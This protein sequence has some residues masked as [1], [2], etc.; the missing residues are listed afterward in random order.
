MPQGETIMVYQTKR[1]VVITGL[2]A[3]AANGIG[4][5]A[6]WDATSK[7]QSGIKPFRRYPSDS[8]PLQVAGEISDFIANDYM[9]RKLVNRTDRMTHFVLASIQEAMQDAGLTLADEDPRR[10]GA[11]IANTFGGLEY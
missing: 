10:V 11:V 2:G 7:G 8:L 1:R 5:K 9:E 6:F 3:V 4:K